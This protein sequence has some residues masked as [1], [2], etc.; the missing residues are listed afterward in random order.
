MTLPVFSVVYG[1]EM[2]QAWRVE[3]PSLDLTR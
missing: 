1:D 2:S 3:S